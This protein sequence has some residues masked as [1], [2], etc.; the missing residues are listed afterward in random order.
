VRPSCVVIDP[1]K[2]CDVKSSCLFLLVRAASWK[3][4]AASCVRVNSCARMQH[5]GSLGTQCFV[6]EFLCV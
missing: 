3:M 5:G 6:P 4:R 1:Q 2:Q